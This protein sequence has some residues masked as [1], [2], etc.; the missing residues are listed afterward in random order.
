MRILGD[1]PTLIVLRILG[2]L[3]E[4]FVLAVAILMSMFWLSREQLLFGSSTVVLGLVFISRLWLIITRR[5]EPFTMMPR[6]DPPAS[7]SRS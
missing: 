3:F 4:V 7:E 2:L 1:N 6:K 5:R